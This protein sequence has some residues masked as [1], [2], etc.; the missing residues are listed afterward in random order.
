MIYLMA[1]MIRTF[2]ESTLHILGLISMK[3]DAHKFILKSKKLSSSGRTMINVHFKSMY[4]SLHITSKMEHKNVLDHA[5]ISGI[6]GS[7]KMERPLSVKLTTTEKITLRVENWKILF[8][9][10]GQYVQLHMIPST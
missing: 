8:V 3:K 4:G 10:T 9:G 5:A 2:I 1:T 6:F 7:Q